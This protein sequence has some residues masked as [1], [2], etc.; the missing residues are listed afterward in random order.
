MK[1]Q[2]RVPTHQMAKADFEALAGFRYRLR[3]FLR[4]AKEVSLRNGVTP[5]QCALMLQ[6][7]ASPV[8]AWL[9]VPG[10]AERLRTKPRSAER[11]I[12]RCEVAGLV[13]RS[14][15]RGDELRA[16]M[17]LTP[18]GEHCLERR[19]RLR[20]DD[21]QSVETGFFV[22]LTAPVSAHRSKP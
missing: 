14:V 3:R 1:G 13:T 7:K 17:H 22:C 12:S 9:T 8:R 4:Y 20:R 19:R 6:I 18:T 21:L 16:E 2:F 5:L 15:S 11:L 10:L